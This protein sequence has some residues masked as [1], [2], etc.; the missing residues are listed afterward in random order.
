MPS[1]G[2]TVIMNSTHSSKTEPSWVTAG[3]I[4]KEMKN[5]H[6]YLFGQAD[7]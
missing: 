7:A 6:K 2:S 1:Y 4:S 5:N 3:C